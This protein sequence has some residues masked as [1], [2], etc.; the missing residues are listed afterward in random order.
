[1]QANGSLSNISDAY[2]GSASGRH[3]GA[4]APTEFCF[5]DSS[6]VVC[7]VDVVGIRVFQA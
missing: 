6:F 2:F 4:T 1:V 7:E 5:R 3:Q